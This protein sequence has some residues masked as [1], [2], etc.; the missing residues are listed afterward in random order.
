MPGSRLSI[1]RGLAARG[2]A[3]AAA[4]VVSLLAVSGAGGSTLQTST[5]GGTVVIG[6]RVPACLSFPVGCAVHD[7]LWQVFEG[8]FEIGPNLTYRPSLVSRVTLTEEPFTLTYHIRPE[9]RWSDGVTVS[10]SDFVFTYKT[11]MTNPRMSEDDPLRTIRRVRAVDTKTFKVVFR[12]RLAGWRELFEL[13]FPRHAL[14]GEDITSIWR[15][16]FDN[17][18]TGEPIGSGPFL[19]QRLDPGRELT[20]VRNPRYWGPHTAY[21]DRLVVRAV[22][23]DAVEALESGQVDMVSPNTP[24]QWREVRREPGLR[25]LWSPGVNWEHFDFRLRGKGHPALRNKLVRRAI[26]YGIDREA[27]LR[28]YREFNPAQRRSD[29]AIFVTQSPYYEPNWKAYRYRPAEARRLLEQAGCRRG[30][31]GTYVCGGRRLSLRFVTTSGSPRRELLLRAVQAQLRRIGVEAVPVFVESG[32]LLGEGGLLEK[33]D[34][35]LVL[36]QWILGADP[37]MLDVF[38]CGGSHNHT[39]YCNHQVSRD[40]LRGNLIVDARA[41]AALLNR[42]DAKLAADV[43][44][45]PLYQESKPVAFRA[46]I[47]NVVANDREGVTWNAEDWWLAR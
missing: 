5:R 22:E 21:L 18:K 3:L 37:D 34:F 20:L 42:V 14:L 40:L 12:R 39:G 11:L 4:I 9:A 36:F 33:G 10:A 17:P 41:R 30:V 1:H 38:G 45:L 8:A 15:D 19:V 25:L 35:D 32:A 7:T 13:V 43:P 2:V 24:E 47:R 23:G 27:I 29:S 46:T 26:A 6:D 28:G 31:D 44:V 16:R